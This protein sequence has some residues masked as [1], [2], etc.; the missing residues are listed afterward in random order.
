MSSKWLSL[1]LAIIVASALLAK[2]PFSTRTLIP[3]LEPFPDSF[4]YLSPPLCYSQG[5]T[6]NMCLR[7][8]SGREADVPPAYSVYLFPFI[9]AT[10]DVRSFYIA[11]VVLALASLTLTHLLIR[12]VS[13]SLFIQIVSLLT[14]TTLYYTYT[15]PT[16][17]MAENLTTFLFLALVWQVTSQNFMGVARSAVLG[18]MLLFTKH[19]HLGFFTGTIGYCA[20]VGLNNATTIHKKYLKPAIVV[21]L[22]LMVLGGVGISKVLSRSLFTIT[23]SSLSGQAIPTGIALLGANGVPFVSTDNMFANLPDYIQILSGQKTRLLWFNQPLMPTWLFTASLAGAAVCLYTKKQRAWIVTVGG[24]SVLQ[25]MATSLFYA[26]DGRYL[27]HLLPLSAILLSA[28]LEKITQLYTNLLLK[29]GYP[30]KISY[31]VALGLIVLPV[32][33]YGL[34]LLPTLKTEVAI[35]LRFEQTPW[36]YRATMHTNEYFSQESFEKKPYVITLIS[37]YY[38]E[39]FGNELYQPLPLSAQQ[40]FKGS[41]AEVWGVSQNQ[42]LPAVY[43]ELVASGAP[44]YVQIYGVTGAAH[45]KEE[46]EQIENTFTLERVTEGCHRACSIF[47]ITSM[48]QTTP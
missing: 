48:Q 18:L 12:R 43:E 20:Y 4:H 27:L 45:F 38:I 5:M 28:F 1:L 39:Y 19:I 10:Q 9:A 34:Q 23:E 15:Y 21:G 17:A 46:L 37:P 41:R 16:L 33:I 35:N 40:D 44:M 36:W 6:W 2:N 13:S 3:N 26:V 8:Q 31:A 30:P 47:K 32:A 22:L 29:A 7:S 14:Y 11:N 25:L 24:I 42:Q